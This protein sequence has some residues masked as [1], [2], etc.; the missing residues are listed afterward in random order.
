M[1]ASKITELMQKRSN[2]YINRAQQSVDAS[3]ITWQRQIQASRYLP[4]ITTATPP[5]NPAN[6]GGCKTCGSFATTNIAQ[7]TQAAYPSPFFS[8][9]G[10][11]SQ[12]NSCDAILYKRA[13]DQMCGSNPVTGSTTSSDQF[14]QPPKCFCNNTDRYLLP[15]SS[16]E[17]SAPPPEDAAKAW[18]NPYLPIPKPYIANT[19]KPPCASC[20]HYKIIDSDCNIVVST[21]IKRECCNIPPPC[22]CCCICDSCDSPDDEIT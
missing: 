10:S 9:K 16:N 14:I 2:T 15:N 20:S 3:L 22:N 1:D 7:N 4:Q 19:E 18:L 13:G 11:A 12:I 5:T 6:L 17:Y 21:R 8:S